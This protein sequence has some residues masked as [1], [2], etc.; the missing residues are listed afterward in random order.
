MMIAENC[1]E[2]GTLFQKKRE[3]QKF[4]TPVCRTKDFLRRQRDDAAFGRQMRRQGNATL[5]TQTH[6]DL[7]AA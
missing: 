3:W 2:C 5:P 4:C 6:R 1:K 7:F